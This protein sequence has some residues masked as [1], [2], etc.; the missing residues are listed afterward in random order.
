[1]VGKGV[2]LEGLDED[3]LAAGKAAR[4]ALL[5]ERLEQIWLACEPFID[6]G[7]SSGAEVRMLEVAL[8]VVDR[9]LELFE[10]L[11]ADRPGSVSEVVVVGSGERRAAVLALLEGVGG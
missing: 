1:M 8:R 5:A 2:A 6:A 11:R 3:G 9:Q 10:V 7:V 4:R